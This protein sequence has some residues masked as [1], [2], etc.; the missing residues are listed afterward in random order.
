MS[1]SMGL[2]NTW[3]LFLTQAKWSAKYKLQ[4]TEE[5]FI[6]LS[7]LYL[8]P[9]YQQLGT[10]FSFMVSPI[11]SLLDSRLFTQ[12]RDDSVSFWEAIYILKSECYY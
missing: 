9:Q 2:S 7:E 6:E 10:W 5:F 12:N 1:L 8:F 4:E 3:K 11:K